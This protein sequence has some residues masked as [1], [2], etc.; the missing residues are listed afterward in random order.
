[1]LSPE[2]TGVK[3]EARSA[4]SHL[5][6]DGEGVLQA[7]VEEVLENGTASAAT[8][9]YAYLLQ[10]CSSDKA[11]AAFWFV[12]TTADQDK[13]NMRWAW[14]HVQY[15][16]G[17]DPDAGA[18]PPASDRSVRR[19]VG[20]K[21]LSASAAAGPVDE[22]VIDHRVSLP[23]LVN[24][25]PLAAGDELLCYKPPPA[26]KKKAPAATITVSRLIKARAAAKAAAE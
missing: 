23:C 3:V 22:R 7:M 12:G 11:L 1:M 2:T 5:G 8:P 17:S 19:R 18:A 25:V 21:S 6:Y 14:H 10:A 9:G 4:P 15:L 13:V 26:T 16:A 20:G 24:T